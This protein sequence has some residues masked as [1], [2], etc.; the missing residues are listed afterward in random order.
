MTDSV[1]HMLTYCTQQLFVPGRVEQWLIVLNLENVALTS[2]PVNALKTF[3]SVAQNTFR[4]RAYRCY[5]INAGYFLRGSW[6]V[7]SSMLDQTSRE[8]TQLLGSDYKEVLCSLI[9]KDQLEE[10][11]G[12]TLPNKTEKFFPPDMGP[13]SNDNITA[14]EAALL[15]LPK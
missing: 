9:D 12:G 7:V 5:V 1:L 6:Y 4:S 10:R 15:Q 14:A 13:E 2:I 8:K 3:L 11:Y